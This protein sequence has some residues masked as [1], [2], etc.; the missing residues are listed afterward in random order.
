M[1]VEVRF[2][3]PGWKNENSEPVNNIEII[4]TGKNRFFKLGSK[5]MNL[6]DLK[7]GPDWQ[8]KNGVA[9]HFIESGTG[10]EP[11]P[12]IFNWD[13]MSGRDSE[14]HHFIG[15]GISA[16]IRRGGS[17]DL[18]VDGKKAMNV[19]HIPASSE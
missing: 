9:I 7:G 15:L 1:T 17:A 2:L 13:V 5:S 19:K 6:F 12:D 18:T 10:F 14:P 3:S 8:D 11:Q 16:H 4:A